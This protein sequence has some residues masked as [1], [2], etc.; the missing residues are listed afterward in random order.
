MLLIMVKRCSISQIHSGL[1]C[2]TPA[3]T[4]AQTSAKISD[5]L[6]TDSGKSSWWR[7]V[8][9]R[10]LLGVNWLDWS[11]TGSCCP[12]N[13][14]C[15][16]SSW[17]CL[18]LSFFSFF[19]MIH[20]LIFCHKPEAK[21]TKCQWWTVEQTGNGVDLRKGFTGWFVIVYLCFFIILLYIVFHLYKNSPRDFIAKILYWNW[22]SNKIKQ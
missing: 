9:H 5:R 17:K 12:V 22:K 21:E 13:W 8:V 20:F 19:W 4:P 7:A 18:P 16:C 14:T 11:G 1:S 10:P 2:Q 3:Q 6:M 15:L